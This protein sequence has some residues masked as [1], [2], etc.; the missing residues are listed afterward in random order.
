MKQAVTDIVCTET[1]YRLL[2]T[3]EICKWMLLLSWAAQIWIASTTDKPTALKSTAS[4]SLSTL[5]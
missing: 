5:Q 2:P 3:A 1:F 4:E